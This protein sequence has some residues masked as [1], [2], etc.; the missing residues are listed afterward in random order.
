MRYGGI[1]EIQTSLEVLEINLASVPLSPH[2]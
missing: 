2:A 1:L